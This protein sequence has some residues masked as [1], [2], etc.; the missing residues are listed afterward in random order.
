MLRRLF[1]VFVFCFSA[2]FTVGGGILLTSL[3]VALP[4]V[5][6]VVFGGGFVKI[7]APNPHE[8]G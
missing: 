7:Y 8:D 2:A 6:I 3:F 4:S 1:F 5:I